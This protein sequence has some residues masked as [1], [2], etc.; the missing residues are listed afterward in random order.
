MKFIHFALLMILPFNSFAADVFTEF[1]LGVQDNYRKVVEHQTNGTLQGTFKGTNFG[2]RVGLKSEDHQAYL[3]YNP[4]QDVEIKSA[5]ELAKVQS[6]FLGYRFFVTSG[7]FVGGQIGMS[8]FELEK[9]PNGVTFTDNPKT[10]GMT[11]GINLGYHYNIGKVL[12]LG[13]DAAYNF[14]SYKKDG[15]SSNAVNTIEIQN[16]TQINLHVGMN[17]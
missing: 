15:P 1:R 14:G 8:S 4:E 11:Y 13:A 2:L 12:Y 17:F 16:Q 9:G 5:N 10:D 7:L 6:T 3:E